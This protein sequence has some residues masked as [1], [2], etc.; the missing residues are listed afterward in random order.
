M[1]DGL[2]SDYKQPEHE[3]AHHIR[4][5]SLLIQTPKLFLE[6]RLAK[7]QSAGLHVVLAHASIR[8]H[9]N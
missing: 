6:R 2:Y 9:L 3:T 4:L 5:K 8:L 1:H 7:A